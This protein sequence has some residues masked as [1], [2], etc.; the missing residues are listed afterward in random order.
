M[1]AEG[2][3]RTQRRGER[4]SM[5]MDSYE[6]GEVIPVLASA[7]WRPGSQ[8][9]AWRRAATRRP[10]PA[11]TGEEE[12]DRSSWA[13]PSEQQIDF[14]HFSFVICFCF[15]ISLTCYLFQLPNSL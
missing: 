1:A 4:M 13:G 11:P 2:I 7:K 3:G 12:D 5:G 9:A 6:L 8:G 14:S 10:P 15:S